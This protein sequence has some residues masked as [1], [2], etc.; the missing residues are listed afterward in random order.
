MMYYPVGVSFNFASLFVMRQQIRRVITVY[1]NQLRN[2]G[3]FDF[4]VGTTIHIEVTQRVTTCFFT[5]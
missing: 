4:Y 5:M 1:L 2:A 3:Q